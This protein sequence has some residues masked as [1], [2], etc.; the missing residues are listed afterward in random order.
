MNRKKL[1]AIVIIF[2]IIIFGFCFFLN[3]SEFIQAG[4]EMLDLD[5]RNISIRYELDRK[6]KTLFSRY[7]L[8][9][10][11]NLNT[12]ISVN[13]FDYEKDVLF[14]GDQN[15]KMDHFL[16]EKIYEDENIITYGIETK[17]INS[18][19]SSYAFICNLIYLKTKSTI[20]YDSGWGEE[21]HL[22]LKEAGLDYSKEFFDESRVNLI[23]GSD[24]E[25]NNNKKQ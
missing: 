5:N 14:L 1:V 25:R 24:K 2:L 22:K 9:Y 21:T 15:S 20:I 19:E 10:E 18:R 16:I 23:Y 11:Y 4:E 6:K 12:T 17:F 7:E 8:R 3:R 13:G